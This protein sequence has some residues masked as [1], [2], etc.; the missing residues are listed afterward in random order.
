M[1]AVMTGWTLVKRLEYDKGILRLEILAAPDASL[2][3]YYLSVWLTVDESE[4]L[5]YCDGGYWFSPEI[6]G[7]YASMP[8]CGAAA[9]AYPHLIGQHASDN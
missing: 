6:P 1:R 4:R 5:Y 9:R 3:R 2:Y 8:E 7:P